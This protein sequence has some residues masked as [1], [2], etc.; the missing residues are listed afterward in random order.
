MHDLRVLPKRDVAV[1]V[2]RLDQLALVK[3]D[4]EFDLARAPSLDD[5]IEELL[6]AGVRQIVIDLRNAHFIDSQGV[7]ILVKYELRSRQGGFEL[8]VISAA[9]QV[10]R[11]FET[12]GVDRLLRLQSDLESLDQPRVHTGN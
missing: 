12:M 2:E 5:Q 3:V 7:Q 1:D 11:V 8:G 9:G 4:G 6:A 10:R